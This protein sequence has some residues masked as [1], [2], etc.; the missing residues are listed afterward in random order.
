[1]IICCIL[2][3]G[4]LL[5]NNTWLKYSQ[6]LW[7]LL[8]V[9]FLYLCIYLWNAASEDP[10]ANSSHTE[11]TDNAETSSRPLVPEATH[12]SFGVSPVNIPRDQMRMVENINALIS[13]VGFGLLKTS[14]QWYINH[15][16]LLI[17]VFGE[18]LFSPI[19][20]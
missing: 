17:T 11:I 20:C 2:N 5:A 1:M 12:S 13:E 6:L 19:S 14:S 3:P 15:L 9:Y 18:I 10:D 8:V 16:S 4:I 7:V